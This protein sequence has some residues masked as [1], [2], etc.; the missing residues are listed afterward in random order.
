M[1]PRWLR[2][3]AAT[4][5]WPELRDRIVATAAERFPGTAIAVAGSTEQPAVRWTDG[6]AG[7]TVAEAI[8]DLP[9]WTLVA[10]APGGDVSV[11]GPVLSVDRVLSD[12]ALAVAVVRFYASQGRHWSSGE[13]AAGQAVWRALTEVDE[14][15]RSGYP[16]PD[17]VA[18]MLLDAPD[19]PHLPAGP[20]RADVLA[21][22]LAALG[23]DKLWAVAF[24]GVS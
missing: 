10:G 8:G 13:G 18:R 19:P 1:A 7:E 17:A 14:P 9:G 11:A 12:E 4:L 3:P 16:I 2:P 22:K 6:P 21:A 15:T 24:A 20:T 5:A 23:Y